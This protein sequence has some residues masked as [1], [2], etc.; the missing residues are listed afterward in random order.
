MPK[1]VVFTLKLESELRDQFMQAAAA[2]HRPASQVVRELMRDFIQAHAHDT[3]F[4]DQVRQAVTEAAD[5]ATKWA[6]RDEVKADM[7]RQ[8]RAIK[9]RMARS[10]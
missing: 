10:K 8:R 5:P 7:Q 9:A 2:S 3:W 4:R 6:T 1:E